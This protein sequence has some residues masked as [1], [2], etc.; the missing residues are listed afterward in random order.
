MIYV[1]RFKDV[2]EEVR[3]GNKKEALKKAIRD[4][5]LGE[6]IP[7]NIKDDNGKEVIGHAELRHYLLKTTGLK[8]FRRSDLWN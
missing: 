1:R 6:F 7:Q 8:E 2:T 5:A 4:W 3:C